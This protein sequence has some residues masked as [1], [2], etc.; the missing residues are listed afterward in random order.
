MSY[1]SKI[2]QDVEKRLLCQAIVYIRDTYRYTGRTKSG[3]EMHYSRRRCSR[4]AKENGLCSQHE[5]MP[6][7]SRVKEIGDWC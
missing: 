1:F 7:I 2:N 4:L 5:K 3:F 6:W